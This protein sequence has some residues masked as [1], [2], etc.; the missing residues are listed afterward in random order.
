MYIPLWTGL[1][2]IQ[3][4]HIFSL[5][6]S[7]RSIYKKGKLVKLFL[8]HSKFYTCISTQINDLLFTTC[9]KILM[10]GIM[11]SEC[12]RVFGTIKY[13]KYGNEKYSINFTFHSMECI[14]QVL[15]QNAQPTHVS[16]F[17]VYYISS[18]NDARNTPV[19]LSQ[20]TKI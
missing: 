17:P 1:L 13:K 14:H 5:Q 2:S 3:L 11:K 7:S 15:T 19:Q 8:I 12:T 9:K 20:C 10:H 4:N 16:S 6:T 18:Y